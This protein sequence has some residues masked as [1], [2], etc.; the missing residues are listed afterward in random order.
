MFQDRASTRRPSRPS[1]E[2]SSGWPKLCGAVKRIPNLKAVNKGHWLTEQRER[3]YRL[4]LNE[5]S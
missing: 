3:F 2:N 1:F 5:A 4:L